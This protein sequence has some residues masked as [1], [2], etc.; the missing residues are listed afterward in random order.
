M[1]FI[2]CL[3]II[4]TAVPLF[5]GDWP[6]WRGPNRDG[7]TT[8]SIKTWP[9]SLTRKWRVVVGEGHSS[10]VVVGERVYIHARQ[11]DNE[12]VRCFNLKDGKPVWE[13]SY[14]APYEM[15]PAARGHGKGPKSTPA[16]AGGR[17]FTFGISGILSCFDAKTGREIW[18]RSFD[19]T[20]KLTSPLYGTAMSPLVYKDTIIAHV[21]GDKRGALTAFDVKTGKTRWEWTREGPGYTSPILF[22]AGDTTHLVTQSKRLTIGVDPATGRELWSLPFRTGYD[23]NSITPV[24]YKDLLIVSGYQHGSQA[25][26]LEKSGAGWKPKPVWSIKDFTMYMSTP[27]LNGKYLFG[28]SQNRRGQLFCAAA[29]T[30]KVLWST[31]GRYS[32]N[33]AL[34][35]AGSAIL[36]QSVEGEV[37]VLEPTYTAMKVIAKYRVSTSPTW[38][39]PALVDKRLLVK[40]KTALICYGVE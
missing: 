24:V 25:Y 38:S 28:L 8:T 22:K 18:R 35:N 16:V 13:K 12:Y 33:A 11:D 2:T 36:V 39:H 23:Q 14:K 21:G 20:Y 10:P 37:Q 6:Q 19:K 9:K 7:R 29:D 31:M 27:V 40:D 3:S 34:I 4:A 26:R 5:A 17:L 30:G 1:H 32:K 15:H